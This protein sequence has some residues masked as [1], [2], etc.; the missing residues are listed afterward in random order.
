MAIYFYRASI[1]GCFYI[2]ENIFL[3]IP[4]IVM[5]LLDKNLEE[6]S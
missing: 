6:Y 1:D 5:F 3:N 4:K 2:L